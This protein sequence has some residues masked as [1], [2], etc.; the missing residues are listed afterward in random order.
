MK[1]RSLLLLT[2]LAS[3]AASAYADDAHPNPP[4]ELTH[5]DTIDVPG[6]VCEMVGYCPSQKLML[7]TD[8]HWD[9]VDVF[10][11]ESLDPPV[12]IPID[13][14]DSTPDVAEGIAFDYEP[15][16]VAVHPNLPIALVTVLGRRPGDPGTVYGF[17]LRPETLGRIILKQHVGAHPDNLAISHDGRY[18]VVACEAERDPDAPGAVWTI[19]LQSLSP[20]RSPDDK[21]LPAGPVPGLKDMLNMPECEVEPEFVAIDPHS[22]FAVVSCQENN[23]LLPVD[24]RGVK[25]TFCKPIYLPEGAEPDGVCILADAQ[26]PDGRTG[27]FVA[28]AEEGMFARYGQLLGQSLS[29]FWIDPNN[30][31]ADATPLARLDVRQLVKPSEPN[32]RR[33]PEAV[34]LVH[35][36]GRPIAIGTTERGDYAYALDLADPT[37]PKLIDKFKIGDRPEGLIV[38]PHGQDLIFVSGDE[39]HYGPGTLSF[40]RLRA[41]P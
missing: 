28:A 27:C 8:T 22:R 2:L 17:D 31:N 32:A 19:D 4:V 7:S 30:L 34:Q 10:R 21:P 12:L 23:L 20:D 25:P 18:A 3:F 11:V 37:N 40:I 29:L 5:L 35:F 36:A 6:F 9:T 39:G 14:D 41:K 16:C 13:F 26:G 1:Y 24:L 38:I 33:D 15:T